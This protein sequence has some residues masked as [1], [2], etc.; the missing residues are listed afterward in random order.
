M[1]KI[2][3][4]TKTVENSKK[5]KK[6]PNKKEAPKSK[7]V[8]AKVN[9]TVLKAINALNKKFGDNCSTTASKMHGFTKRGIKR[10][11]TGSIDLDIKLG[12][13]IPIGRVTHISGA[14][15]S[16]KTTQTIHII[17]EA[18]KMGLV[19]ALLDFEDTSTTDYL[20]KLGVDIENLIYINPV[21]LEEC[22]DLLIELQQNG[23]N[24]LIWDSVAVS[25]AVKVL[26]SKMDETVQM[27]TKQKLIG[28][29]L[30]K[31]QS[32]NNGFSRNGETPCTLIL[33]NQLREKIGA[34]GD[35]EYEP[36]GRAIGFY[37]SV[38][39]RIRRGDFIY[40]GKGDNKRVVAQ[41]VKYK[42]LKNK[43]YKRMQSGEFDFYQDENN[44]AGVPEFYNDNFKSAIILALEYG[45]IEQ[46]GAWYYFDRGTENEVK[47]QGL[48]KVINYLREKPEIVEGFKEKILE[49]ENNKK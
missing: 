20:L 46:G 39:I 27:G 10:I 30:A 17:R 15:S 26:N 37:T 48:D 11:P 22:T 13:G 44:V 23:V 16:T 5:P 24:L 29:Y 41:E 18:Q 34:Y 49:I 47:F 21:S 2:Q 28:E 19:C 6:E 38:H 12:G 40:E 35:P 42:I 45:L 7:V 43:T 36:G 14:F 3:K 31:F 9:P 4:K 1:S 33:I 32:L 25:E 8:E